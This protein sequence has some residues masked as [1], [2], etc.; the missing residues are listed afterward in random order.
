MAP[1]PNQPSLCAA[2]QLGG[3][4]LMFS[5]LR[6]RGRCTATLM[7]GQSRRPQSRDCVEN[8]QVHNHALADATVMPHL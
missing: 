3:I 2:V 7:V 6:I 1:Q 8:V 5:K 4:N